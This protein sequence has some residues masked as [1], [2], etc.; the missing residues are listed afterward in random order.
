M[1]IQYLSMYSKSYNV[2]IYLRKH[3]SYFYVAYILHDTNGIS[4]QKT[5][6]SSICSFDTK[7]KN[8]DIISCRYTDQNRNTFDKI[9]SSTFSVIE[10]ACFSLDKQENGFR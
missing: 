9:Q 7:Y 1:L 2:I 8:L 6:I 10:F 4:R 5:S 3:Q